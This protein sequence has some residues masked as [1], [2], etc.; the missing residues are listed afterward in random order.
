MVT[1][2]QLDGILFIKMFWSIN[3][4][5]TGSSLWS[6]SVHGIRFISEE[7]REIIRTVTEDSCLCVSYHGAHFKNFLSS[8]L[9]CLLLLLFIFCPYASV[10]DI[11]LCV[12]TAKC[13][14]MFSQQPSWHHSLTE[15]LRSDRLA[16]SNWDVEIQIRFKTAMASLFIL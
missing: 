4:S 7:T 2:W 12:A 16:T 10:L 1:I 3:R 9:W 5:E 11:Q 13:L 8:F 6:L 15:I 14:S